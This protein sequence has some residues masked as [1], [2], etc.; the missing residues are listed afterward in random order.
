MVTKC[1]VAIPSFDDGESVSS[2]VAEFCEQPKNSGIE[3]EIIVVDNGS[4]DP[5][6]L[7]LPIP[8]LRIIRLD[9]NMGFG[10]AVQ[11]AM[12]V[13]ESPFFAWMPGNKKVS[14]KDMLAAVSC[15]MN[16]DVDILKATRSR[17][18]SLEK[19]KSLSAQ[20]ALTAIFRRPVTD[21]GGTP[22]IVKTQVMRSHL[23]AGPNGIEFEA[24]VLGLMI[25]GSFSICRPRVPYGSRGIGKSKWRKGLVSEAA[26]FAR[27]VKALSQAAKRLDT[28]RA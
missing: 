5:L 10:G 24:Y 14:P 11:A 18:L 9:E 3:I 4:R 20:F 22:T 26:L 28:R 19:V 27:A 1:T 7:D 25:F 15:A 23:L 21:F 2:L 16:S 8:F 6:K 12:K 13:S 17:P